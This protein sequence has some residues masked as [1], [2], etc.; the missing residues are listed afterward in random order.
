MER[1]RIARN[2]SKGQDT[3]NEYQCFFLEKAILVNIQS[4]FLLS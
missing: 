4:I 2:N 3:T 1:R